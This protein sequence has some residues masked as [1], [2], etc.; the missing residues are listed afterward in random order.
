MSYRLTN[1]LFLGFL[2]ILSL[3]YFMQSLELVTGSDD[4]ILSAG[5]YPLILSSFLIIL[6]LIKLIQTIIKGDKETLFKVSNLKYIITTV[7]ILVAYIWL[8]ASFRDFFY[9]FTILF[10][11]ALTT[12]YVEKESRKNIKFIFRNLAVS[13]FVTLLIYLI[14]DLVFSIRF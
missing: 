4:F 13:V 9:L 10:L 3:W 8:W 6:C 2:L 14:F 12:I 7:V 5:F 11:L 1:I